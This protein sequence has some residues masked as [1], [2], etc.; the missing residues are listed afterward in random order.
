MLWSM[1]NR[2]ADYGF[3][4]VALTSVKDGKQSRSFRLGAYS[5]DYCSD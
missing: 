5:I 2:I 3:L 4:I 1:R